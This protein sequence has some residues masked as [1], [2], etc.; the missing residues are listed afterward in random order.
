MATREEQTKAAMKRLAGDQPAAPPA[1]RPK[2]STGSAA[3]SAAGNVPAIGGPIG[4][5]AW[6]TGIP[7]PPARD[8][9]KFVWAAYY[10]DLALFVTQNLQAFMQACGV[11]LS[12]FSE[13]HHIPP[14]AIKNNSRPAIG[15]G[16]STFQETWCAAQCTLA[17][18]TTGK[19][20]AP[21]SL[22]WFYLL[23][24]RVTFLESVLFEVEPH[25]AAVEAAMGLW[26][27]AAYR[28]SDLQE[29]R[30]RYNFPGILPTGCA[31]IPDT[32]QTLNIENFMDTPTFKNLPLV[33]GRPAV[34]AF[35]EAF[36][37][38]M[39]CDD[40]HRAKKLFEARA[41]PKHS[42]YSPG[43]P[44]VP[45]PHVQLATACPAPP[46]FKRP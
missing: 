2:Q 6:V 24:G 8:S 38:C 23:G 31:G 19:Y 45:N 37:E 34:L 22:W 32:Q 12:A 21:G 7:V 36:S 43:Y 18:E 41:S 30:R 28:A 4:V 40:K 3:G 44:C 17:M 20:Q 29:H 42:T 13:L 25:R 15:G 27:D 9:G 14:T 26:D 1:Q 46:K 5:P 39:R 10:K 11:D 35:F 33:A 16:L